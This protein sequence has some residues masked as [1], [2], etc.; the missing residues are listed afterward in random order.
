MLLRI[1]HIDPRD[2]L[3]LFHGADVGE[4]CILLEDVDERLHRVGFGHRGDQQIELIREPLHCVSVTPQNSSLLRDKA[5][6]LEGP[7]RA[8]KVYCIIHLRYR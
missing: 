7:D 6:L 5:E 1:H 8:K 2:A 3:K 4:G